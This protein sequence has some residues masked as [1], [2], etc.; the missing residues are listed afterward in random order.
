MPH[1]GRT[2][3][4]R[5]TNRR[6][7]GAA[8]SLQPTRG[9][10]I[11]RWGFRDSRGSRKFSGL[12]F[13][14]PWVMAITFIILHITIHPP[15]DSYP[16]QAMLSKFKFKF[17]NIS[18]ILDPKAPPEIRVRQYMSMAS[19]WMQRYHWRFA[20]VC[21][22]KGIE[23]YHKYKL[24]RNDLFYCELN[25]QAA[26]VYLSHAAWGKARDHLD[27]ARKVAEKNGDNQLLSMIFVAYS[28][29]YHMKK[30][31]KFAGRDHEEVTQNIKHQTP[32]TN[33]QSPITN[34]QSPI[35]NHQS[36]PQHPT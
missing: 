10:K 1:G 29:L 27:V 6:D 15:T 13:C 36:E 3:L 33:Q 9:P 28:N 23:T 20:I 2:I 26:Y 4:I 19:R 25:L 17:R 31:G 22:M 8:G 24:D 16:S 34:H 30:R 18:N 21:S 14:L 32:T 12:P 35:T 5:Q 11:D 7:P